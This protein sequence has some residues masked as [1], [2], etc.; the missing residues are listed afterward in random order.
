MPMKVPDA[1]N[2]YQ[3]TQVLQCRSRSRHQARARAH[4]GSQGCQADCH[5]SSE[6][7]SDLLPGAP[8]SRT[9]D[10]CPGEPEAEGAE[11]EEDGSKT[12]E[13]DDGYAV[14]EEVRTCGMA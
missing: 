6:T 10:E 14:G 13:S 3:E 4:Q 5:R 9:D 11:A 2:A 12:V 7:A 8:C 1:W